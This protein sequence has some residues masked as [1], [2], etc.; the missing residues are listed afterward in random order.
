MVRRITPCGQIVHMNVVAFRTRDLGSVERFSLSIHIKY[1][2][3]AF[4][5][6]AIDAHRCVQSITDARDPI[7]LIQTHMTEVRSHGCAV[8]LL[9]EFGKDEVSLYPQF[10]LSRHLKLS[11]R[12]MKIASLNPSQ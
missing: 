2:H 8:F 3:Q 12:H 4:I 5:D 9:G 6:I 1:V 10:P 11:M 7:R